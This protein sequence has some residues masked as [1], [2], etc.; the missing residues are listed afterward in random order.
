[1]TVGKAEYIGEDLSAFPN[2]PKP[3]KL[4]PYT[5]STPAELNRAQLPQLLYRGYM[6]YGM[7]V[8]TLIH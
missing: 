1:M 7:R 8:S 4:G 3:Y 2:T 6:D 5:P